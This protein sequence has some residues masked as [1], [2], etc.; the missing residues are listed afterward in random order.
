VGDPREIAPFHLRVVVAA[1]PG[2]DGDLL[3]A[4]PLNPPSTTADDARLVRREAGSARA[5]ELTYFGLVVHAS[6]LRPWDAEKEVLP[7]HG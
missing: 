1:H 4:T 3:A 6:T 5:K 7:V 2:E